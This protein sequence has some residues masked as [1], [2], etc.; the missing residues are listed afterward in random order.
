[1]PPKPGHRDQGSEKRHPELG[2]GSSNHQA[3]KEREA[4]TQTQLQEEHF[5]HR[6]EGLPAIPED[7]S[8]R[9]HSGS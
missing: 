3:E 1:M 4:L 7:K 2:L 6:E 8:S 5:S 9:Q